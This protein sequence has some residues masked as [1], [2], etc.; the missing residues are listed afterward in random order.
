MSARAS[1]RGKRNLAQRNAAYERWL[2]LPGNVNPAERK[3][4]GSQNPKKSLA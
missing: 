3:R 4:P 1:R 2:A